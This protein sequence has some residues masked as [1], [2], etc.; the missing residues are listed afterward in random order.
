MMMT[1]DYWKELP[2]RCRISEK[3]RFN[4]IMNKIENKTTNSTETQSN[5]E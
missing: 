5:G 2:L 1:K 3:E 4:Y